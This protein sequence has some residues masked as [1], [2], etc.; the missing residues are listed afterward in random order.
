[1]E[2]RT[3][4]GFRAAVICAVLVGNTA[5]A[6]AQTQTT[7][8]TV[9]NGFNSSLPSMSRLFEQAATSGFGTLPLLRD[10]VVPRLTD[11]T[12]RAFEQYDDKIAPWVK[13]VFKDF[14]PGSCGGASSRIAPTTDWRTPSEPALTFCRS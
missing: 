13:R 1:M 2:S 8:D 4:N 12:A 14:K 3:M 11:L 10:E 6:S 9:P 7:R 5:A